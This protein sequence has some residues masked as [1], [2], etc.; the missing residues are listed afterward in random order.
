MKESWN[1]LFNDAAHTQPVNAPNSR[2]WCLSTPQ[3]SATEIYKHCKSTER[4]KCPIDIHCTQA[5]SRRARGCLITI[6]QSCVELIWRVQC[7]RQG[8]GRIIYSD[9]QVWDVWERMQGYQRFI[10][11]SSLYQWLWSKSNIFK[12]RWY[13]F[14][15]NMLLKRCDNN[16]AV[17]VLNTSLSLSVH[18]K[19]KFPLMFTQRAPQAEKWR[20]WEARN[21]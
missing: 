9:S 19:V 17:F 13:V 11:Q 21:R 3:L 8:Q 7:C 1:G 15:N 18:P 6:K 2:L 5:V 4:C 20:C 10:F 16:S 14:P 12:V